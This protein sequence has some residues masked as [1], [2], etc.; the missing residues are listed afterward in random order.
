VGLKL[1]GGKISDSE[2]EKYIEGWRRR[3]DQARRRME[4]Q[5]REAFT[6][7][8][9]LAGKLAAEPGVKRVWLYG[10]LAGYFKGYR[11]FGED[12]DIDLAVEGLSPKE[13]FPVLARLNRNLAR[14]V[15]LIDLD[16]CP[17]ALRQAVQERGILLYERPEPPADP[18]Q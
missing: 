1:M 12:S 17:A 13:Y 15:D 2:M 4:E 11:H 8:K 9:H 10:S 7:A 6:A 14:N 5:A 18:R 3:A 16:A